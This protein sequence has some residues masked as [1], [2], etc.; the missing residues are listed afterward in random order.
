M[1]GLESDLLGLAGFKCVKSGYFRYILYLFFFN[2]YV[3][4]IL[5]FTCF[6][7]GLAPTAV[8]LGCG[9]KFMAISLKKT[10]LFES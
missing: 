7:Y 8:H 10:C 3:I 6:K 1:D 5:Q 9:I 2:V 4:F